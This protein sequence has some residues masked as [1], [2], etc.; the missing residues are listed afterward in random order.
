MVLDK[1]GREKSIS[2]RVEFDV[3]SVAEPLNKYDSMNC[4]FAEALCSIFSNNARK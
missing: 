2:G 1:R 3:G 4:L